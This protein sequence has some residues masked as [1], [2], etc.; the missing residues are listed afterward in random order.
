MNDQYRY[1]IGHPSPFDLP[2]GSQFERGRVKGYPIDF[3]EKAPSSQWPPTDVLVGGYHRFI[4]LG[5]W[6]LGAFE[7]Y[8]AGDPGSWMDGLVQA[9]EF[10]VER[11]IQSGVG[12][13]GWAEPSD[14][15]ATFRI[16]G[17]WLS[18]MAQGEC[19]SLLVR[20]AVETGREEFA[21]AARRGISPYSVPVWKGGVQAQLDGRLFPEEYPTT[22][23]SYVLN[24]A[25]FAIWGLHDVW[26]GLGDDRTGE[27]YADAVGMLAETVHRWDLGYWSRYD[28]YRH[29]WGVNN[30]ANANYHRLHITQL[31]AMHRLEPRPQFEAMAARFRSYA[32]RR[33]NVLRAY[34]HKA[35]FRVAVPRGRLLDGRVP[36]RSPAHGV[37]A[38]DDGGGNA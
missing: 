11:Q 6:G 17:P 5:Q 22:P 1:R 31:E 37:P 35:A 8:L 26:V 3:R 10:L 15:R 20:L 13:G 12:Q 25:I 33:G 7:R 2:I 23:S 4:G 19:A 28:L 36:W 9:G 34:A 32:S 21:Q 16:R 24:G 27:L 30:V 29:R 14:N 38:P 18:A